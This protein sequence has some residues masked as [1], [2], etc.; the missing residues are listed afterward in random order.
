MA[1]T[2]IGLD[3]GST[4]AR[5]AEINSSSDPPSL[6]RAAQVP[7]QPGAVENGEIK[8]PQAVT[9]ALKELWRRGGFKGRQ[10]YM[11]V[12]NQRVVVREVALP[13]LPLKELREALPYHVQEFIP[14]AVED[15]V[16]DFDPLDEFEQ[17]G[18]RMLRVL[19]VAAQKAMVN[20]LVQTAEAAR[21]EPVGI[22]LTPFA[23]I[24]AVGEPDGG[25][26]LGEPGDE[27]VIDVGAD[28]TSICV[29]E[30]SV[31]RFVRIL[32]SGGNDI[33]LAV[34]RALAVPEDVAER[35]KRGEA[36]EG[37]PSVEDAV[38]VAAG[39]AVSFVD[40]I[41]SSLEFYTAQSPGSKVARLTV[42]GGGSKLQGFL[43]LLG[44]RMS[45]PVD[46][47]HPF[48]RVRPDL[49]LSESA[50]AEAEPLLAVAVGLALPGG[51]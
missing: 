37:S 38:R 45:A 47:G 4:A 42:T 32:P 49:E 51:R 36:V 7:M 11:G 10:V 8:D 2:R 33:T 24:R 44:Q 46:R 3:I 25:P 48:G 22:D 18:R 41:R 26:V 16:L 31:P 50:L 21:L 40:E 35:L 15:A 43:P 19:L 9:E 29:H 14:I 5:A 34:S 27:A 12:G 13:W 23:L 17:E 28:V 39:R 20:A 6:V 1:R 30:R